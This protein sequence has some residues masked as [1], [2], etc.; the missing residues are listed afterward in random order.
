LVNN[1]D[2]AINDFVSGGESDQRYKNFL[3][4]SSDIQGVPGDYPVALGDG[5][6][7]RHMNN[8][9]HIQN[10]LL[11]IISFRGDNPQKR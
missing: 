6:F 3:P 7:Y 9:K 5:P 1:D 8:K 11:I 4:S 10:L 2:G